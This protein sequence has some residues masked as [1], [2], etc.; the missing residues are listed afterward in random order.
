MVVIIF[1]F[2]SSPRLPFSIKLPIFDHTLPTV[3][4]MPVLMYIRQL[5]DISVQIDKLL[6]VESSYFS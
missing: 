3:I 4:Y 1:F 2:F 5:D 6:E